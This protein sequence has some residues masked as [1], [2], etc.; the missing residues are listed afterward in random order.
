MIAF[1]GSRKLTAI[2]QPLVSLIVRRFTERYDGNIKVGVGDA[3]GAD[4]L[5]RAIAPT[6]HV[7]R[8]A[9]RRPFALAIRSQEMVRAASSLVAFADRAC[10][11]GLVPGPQPFNGFGSGTWATIAYAIHLGKPVTM[12]ALDD[13]GRL[14]QWESGEWQADGWHH[15]NCGEG[16]SW[17]PAQTK[18]F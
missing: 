18:L 13:V 4:A 9:D 6:A 5:V 14:P 3:S 7:F 16:Y 17:K 2:H 15:A 1:T 10:P 11:V 8:S 12:F